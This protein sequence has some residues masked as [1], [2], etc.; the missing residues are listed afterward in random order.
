M[1]SLRVKPFFL[2]VIFFKATYS[3][4]FDI[5]HSKKYNNTFGG[6]VVSFLVERAGDR[7]VHPPAENIID[8][9]FA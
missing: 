4:R 9:F 3:N 8:S 7:V 5:S 6:V 2:D 1:L